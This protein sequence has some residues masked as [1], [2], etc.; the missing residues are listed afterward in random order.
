MERDAETIRALLEMLFQRTGRRYSEKLIRLG[1]DAANN[2][3]IE[4]PD[5]Y[6]TLTGECGDRVEFFL[7][8]SDG[9]VVDAAFTIDGCISAFASMAAAAEMA[10]GRTL[11][12]CLGI[13]Q[14]AIAEYLGGMPEE[15][16]HCALL[17]A[18]ALQKA[19]RDFAVGKTQ[20]G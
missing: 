17:A 1:T 14:S 9:K 18:R 15:D 2:R 11:R 5:G 8:V 16:R 13:N 19:L 7:R 4:R 6:A 20:K 12:G 10:R 3:R